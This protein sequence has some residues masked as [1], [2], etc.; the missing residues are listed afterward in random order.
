MELVKM[1][2]TRASGFSMV[3]LLVVSAIALTLAAFATPVVQR[4]WQAYRLATAGNEVSTFIQRARFEAIRR[5]TTVT[6]RAVRQD[7]DRWMIW[8][9]LDRNGVLSGS[10]PAI[11][12][13]RGVEFLNGG[14]VP[15]TESMGYGLTRVPNNAIAFDS[16]GTVD[17]GG[18]PP[19]VLTFFLGYPRMPDRGFRAVTVLPAG[20]TKTWYAQPSGGWHSY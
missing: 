14:N 9:D 17:F 20:R 4:N 12:L 1:K 13:P 10:E 18:Q 3:E 8:I 15:S 11:V 5:N 7:E 6:A 19:A 16:R 2:K